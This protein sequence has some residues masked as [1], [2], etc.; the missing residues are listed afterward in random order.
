[1]AEDQPS[2]LAPIL[3]F[4]EFA[5][6]PLRAYTAS[7]TP[8]TQGVL[9]E[10]EESVPLEAAL[11]S[12]PNLKSL[13]SLVVRNN[14]D[15]GVPFRLLVQSPLGGCTGLTELTVNNVKT[16]FGFHMTPLYFSPTNCLIQSESLGRSRWV[17]S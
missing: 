10:N 6:T 2:S 14:S 11:R 8:L 5:S 15:L 12:F 3:S 17:G 1:M 4:P 13:E 16:L 9:F 7:F